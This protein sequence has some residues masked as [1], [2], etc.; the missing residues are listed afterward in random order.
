MKLRKI[1]RIVG[2]LA[3]WFIFGYLIGL[4]ISEKNTTIV[5]IGLGICIGGFII[6]IIK[7]VF[8]RISYGK[9]V[10]NFKGL[11]YYLSQSHKARYYCLLRGDTE[12]VKK[13]EEIMEMCSK[14][15]LQVG[16]S[17]AGYK[18]VTKEERKE[19]LE[20]IDKTKELMATI[21]PPV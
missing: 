19:V 8:D 7:C 3:Y 11:F 15:I 2:K 16:P 13:F 14:S 5:N 10:K 12:G 17:I 18:E 20:M 4:C 1:L 6:Y 9:T 21:Q